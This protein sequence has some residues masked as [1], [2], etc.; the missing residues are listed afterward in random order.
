MPLAQSRRSE[1]NRIRPRA[2]WATHVNISSASPAAGVCSAKDQRAGNARTDPP[3]DVVEAEVERP[4]PDSFDV[5]RFDEEQA[6]QALVANGNDSCNP[7]LQ[8]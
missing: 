2:T 5:V 8:H 7:R 4:Q 1:R 3:D 6:V